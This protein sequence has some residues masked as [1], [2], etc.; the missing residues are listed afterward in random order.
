MSNNMRSTRRVVTQ[1][2]FLIGI[3]SLFTSCGC[4]PLDPPAG[5]GT[6]TTIIDPG[7]T[8]TTV[9]PGGTTTTVDPGGTTTTTTTVDP[10]GTTTTVPGGEPGDV[11]NVD[12]LSPR[13]CATPSNEDM[14]VDSFTL[15]DC[16]E[17]HAM[18]VIAS[19]EIAQG[20]YPGSAYPGNAR[21][22]PDS[23]EACQ[24]RFEEYVGVSLWDSAYDITTITPSPSTW[25]EG[26]RTIT[27]L[28]VSADESP[29]T[30]AAYESRA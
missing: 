29:L 30:S 16:D 7:G 25:A 11:V 18:E 20:E 5:G 26:D 12:S 23:Y 27:C 28:L 6:T 21:L 19:F 22:L 2:L 13:D 10:G 9:D 15:A 17:P 1:G 24:P 3:A 14:F 4:A 8:T